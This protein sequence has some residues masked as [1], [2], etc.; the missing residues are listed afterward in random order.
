MTGL[1]RLAPDINQC[2]H[3]NADMGSCVSNN[4]VCGFFMESGVIKKEKTGYIRKQRWYEQ[5]YKK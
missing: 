2:P 5:Y 3:Y 1:C 4:K